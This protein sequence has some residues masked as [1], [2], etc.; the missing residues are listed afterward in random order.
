MG[1]PGSVDGHVTVTFMPSRRTIDVPLGTTLYEAARA[2][3]LPVGSSCAAEG[4]CG[5]CGL[6]PVLGA[7]NLSPE[8]DDER[9]VKADNRVPADL[10]L[11]C[12]ARLSGAVV[13]TASY[14]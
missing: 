12:V 3:G 14:W 1:G 13:A 2:V 10:R 4:V 8:T 6:R 11:S 7:E 9:K 5:R